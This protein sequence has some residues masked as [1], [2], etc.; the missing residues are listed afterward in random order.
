[1]AEIFVTT[2]KVFSEIAPGKN[3]VVQWKNVQKIV[4]ISEWSGGLQI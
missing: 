4:E 2:F 1:M 3:P